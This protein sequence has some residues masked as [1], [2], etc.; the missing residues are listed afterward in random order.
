MKSPNNPASFVYLPHLFPRRYGMYRVRLKSQSLIQSTCSRVVVRL[1]SYWTL[2][3][4]L[5]TTLPLISITN[6][7]VEIVAC[8]SQACKGPCLHVQLYRCVY[9]LCVQL[10][11][12]HVCMKSGFLLGGA[13]GG[14]SPPLGNFLPP[15]E[16]LGW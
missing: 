1:S 7:Y 15:L 11:S 2:R 9:K 13:G 12:I 5:H 14:H 4:A 3:S 10:Y 8:V 16:N 6:V